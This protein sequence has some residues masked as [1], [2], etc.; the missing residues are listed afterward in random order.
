LSARTGRRYRLP[1]AGEWRDATW[2]KFWAFGAASPQDVAWL[3]DNSPA[4]TTHPVAKLA[5]NH[6]GLHDLIGNVAEW[7][8]GDDGTPVVLGG[9]FQTDLAAMSEADV[10]RTFLTGDPPSPAW[11]AND[12]SFPRS[13]WWLRD[14]PFVGFRV[15]CEEGPG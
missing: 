12:P 4:G 14:A 6:F 10:D 15:V 9:S 7:C 3:A 13:K 5:P 11:N 2:E 8:V 1:T